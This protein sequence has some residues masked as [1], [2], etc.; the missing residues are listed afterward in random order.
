MAQGWKPAS[1]GKV[2]PNSYVMTLTAD[3]IQVVSS[4]PGRTRLKI[5]RQHWNSRRL[6]QMVS[7]LKAHEKV[8]DVRVNTSCGSIVV[9]YHQTSGSNLDTL[10]GLLYV[11]TIGNNVKVDFREPSD[12]LIDTIANPSQPEK[13]VT[14]VIVELLLLI[15]LGLGALGIWQLVC[16]G[17]QIEATP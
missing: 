16:Q 17:L 14:Y 11:Q 7:V 15:L 13:P 12:K 10:S 3:D 2:S 4:I 5:S 6:E 1:N 8:Y 9:L